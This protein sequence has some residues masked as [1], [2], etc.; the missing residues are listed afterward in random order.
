MQL[1]AG[2]LKCRNAAIGLQS[3]TQNQPTVLGT[4]VVNQPSA[5]EQSAF[6]SEKWHKLS[7]VI[8]LC[9]LP[10]AQPLGPSYGFAAV[11]R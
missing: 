1:F 3:E 11:G 7:D 10:L 8:S 4:V 9:C 5:F 2:N 6:L